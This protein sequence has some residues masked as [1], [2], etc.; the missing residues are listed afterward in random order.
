M[1]IHQVSIETTRDF[2]NVTINFTDI[3][4]RD[5][6]LKGGLNPGKVV[7]MGNTYNAKALDVSVKDQKASTGELDFDLHE[8]NHE[9]VRIAFN[10]DPLHA[11]L[12][13]A[14]YMRKVELKQMTKAEAL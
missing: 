2:K 7:I 13:Q 11:I 4:D 10:E 6:A 3:D 14:S 9:L 1:K 5:Q 8:K 12:R